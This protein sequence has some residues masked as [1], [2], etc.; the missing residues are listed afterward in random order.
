MILL[1]FGVGI[2]FSINDLLAVRNVA[3]PGCDRPDP[4]RD[5]ARGSR[6]G[7]ALGWGLAGGLVLGPG[8]VGREHD[9]APAGTRTARRGR[10]ATGTGRHRLADRRRPLH[11]P[12]ARPAADAGADA[13]RRGRERRRRRRRRR[14]RDRQGR[15]CSRHSC[16]SS[17]CG[18]CRGC[19]EWV[20][21][22]RSR[23]LF[24]L[25]VLAVAIGIAAAAY[26]L[27]GVSFAL[28]AFLAGVVL[29][30][31]RGQPPGGRGCTA[32]ARRLRRPVLRV[33]RDAAGPVV[34]DRAAD[35]P[36]CW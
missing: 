36:S 14:H 18:S 32:D 17:G 33:G 28:G 34:P 4:R 23:E 26:A 20:E 35:A 10:L 8:G 15:P 6:F 19:C 30:E 31:S 12:R 2:H 1:M 13:A 16:W 7:V 24:T 3:D 22:T 27:F 21:G 9:R 11:G 29:N 25:S 5:P